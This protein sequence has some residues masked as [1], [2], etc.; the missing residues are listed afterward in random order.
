VRVARVASVLV[1]GSRL[2]AILA[3]A[4]LPCCTTSVDSLGYDDEEEEQVT[5]GGLRPL[6]RPSAYPNPF[7]DVLGRSETQIDG[8]IEAAFQQLFHGLED[9]EAVYFPVGSDQALIRDI[10]HGD[11]RTEG[12]GFGMMIAVEL[13]RKDEFDRLWRYAK[14]ELGATGA[15][16]GYYDSFCDNVDGLTSIRCI[17]PFGMEQFAMALV[18]AHG[19]WKSD[20]SIDYAADALELLDVMRNKEARNGGIVDDVT[21]VFDSVT[22]LVFHEPKVSASMFTRPSLE[23]P[24]YYALWAQATGDPFWSQV[25]DAARAYTKRVSHATTGLVPVRAYL[26]GRPVTGSGWEAF[27]HEAYRS[28]IN[29]ALDGIWFPGD[30]WVV[31]TSDRIIGFFSSQGIDTYGKAY[32]L[33]GAVLDPAREIALVAANGALAGISTRSDRVGFI[34]AVWDMPTPSG[35]ARYY[36]GMLHLLSLLVLGGRFQVY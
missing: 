22:K 7:R 16:A 31:E 26:D 35:G 17:D 27:R 4:A 29:L 9:S 15:N 28:E 30:P 36:A 1:S 5:P 13:D 24:A 2:G 11:E 14:A 10:L 20:G 25:T 21:N 32:T 23:I 12:F 3:L 19:R 34:Q 6:D 33:D 8:K 18:F